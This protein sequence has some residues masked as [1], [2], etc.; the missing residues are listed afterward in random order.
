MNNNG[1]EIDHWKPPP[2]DYLTINSDGSFQS[3]NNLGGIGLIVRNCA[4]TQRAAKCIHLR[5]IRNAEHAEGLGLWEAVQW[6]KEQNLSK[7]IFELDAKLVVDAVYKDQEIIDWRMKNLINDI[8][9]NR[10]AD[11]LSKL[12]RVNGVTKTWGLEPPDVILS[13]LDEDAKNVC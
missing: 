12:S 11:I 8:K 13:Q 5:R 2:N 3:V 7:V 4:G 6:S 10:V 9:Q 1:Q